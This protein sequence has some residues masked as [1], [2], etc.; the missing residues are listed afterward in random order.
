MLSIAIC[1]CVFVFL[2]ENEEL[3]KDENFLKSVE[4]GVPE[5][6]IW[7]Y[8]LEMTFLFIIEVLSDL[9]IYQRTTPNSF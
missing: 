1:E 3:N 2:T 7:I 5:K 6:I 4:V 8:M 9:E